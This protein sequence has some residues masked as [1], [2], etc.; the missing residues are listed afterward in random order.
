M[1]I[2]EELEA[3]GLIAQT[4]HKEQICDLLNNKRA[5]FYVGFDPTADSLHVGSFVPFMVMA[6]LQRAGHMPIALF[7]G[8]TGMIGDPSGKTDMRK[9]MTA[10]TIAHNI[11]KFTEQISRFVEFGDD[12]GIIVNNKDWL[13]NL[14]YVEFLRDVGVHFSIN[15]MLSAECYKQRLE[16]GLSFFELNY[17]IMQSYDFLRLNR[18]YDCV[19]QVGGDD[20]WSNIIGGVE[21]CRRMDQKDVYGMTIPLLLTA[22]GRKMG[23][24]E[25]GA[26]WLDA[27]KTS[28]YDFFQYWRNIDDAS[29]INSM[30]MLTFMPLSEIDEFAKL[31]GSELNAAKERLAYEIT[32]NVHGKEAADN[33]LSAAKAVFS[34]GGASDANMPC[35]ALSSGDFADGTI[36]IIDLLVKT[37][38]AGSKGDARRLITGGGV[39]LD[40]NK[41]ASLDDCL[42]KAQA[43]S[44]VI[45]RKG[46]KVYHKIT[47][48]V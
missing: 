31:S 7:G 18:E 39:H 38:L 3:R 30:K 36:L 48:D 23:K 35:T 11:A 13:C 24:T 10:D 15:R 22:D 6:H 43:E 29:V 44:G 16:K 40:D 4:T 1:H 37:G 45:L 17:M 5:V 9:M 8:G 20:Q 26:V 25:Q 32:A 2:F 46:K 14:N 21:L 47:L 19:L 41:I 33:A 28:P 42:T 27:Q 34:G 12:K